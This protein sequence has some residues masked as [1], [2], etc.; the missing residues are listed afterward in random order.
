MAF[1]DA[2]VVGQLAEGDHRIFLARV[3]A[4]AVLDPEAEPFQHVR[5][6]GFH[7]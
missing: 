6:N 7:Y 3:V 5:S 4:G 1:L 2:E